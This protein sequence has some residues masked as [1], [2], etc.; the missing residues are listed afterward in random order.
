MKAGPDIK[1][2]SP[3]AQELVKAG[4][5]AGAPTEL[6]KERIR[7][8]LQQRLAAPPG[9]DP[10]PAAPAVPAAPWSLIAGATLLA[11]VIAGV[12]VWEMSGDVKAPPS[13]PAPAS[14]A[15]LPSVAPSSAPA[16]RSENTRLAP[17]E[18]PASKPLPA[19]PSAKGSSDAR[20]KNRL[21]EEIALLS[22]ATSALH[23]GRPQDALS[24]LAE[25]QRRFPLGHLSV[26]RIAARAQA[27]CQLGRKAEGERELA[28]LPSASPQAARARRACGSE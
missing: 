21:A 23:A 10:S 5:S 26:E 28:R 27:L 12:L 25:H 4:R 2:L 11:G 24:A 1:D 20:P 16:L 7:E 18:P 15:A 14:S 6:D 13:A 3:L 19:A 9:P 17:A 22:R 8:A